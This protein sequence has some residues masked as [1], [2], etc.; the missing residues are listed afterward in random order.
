MKNHTFTHSLTQLI[1]CPGNRSFRCRKG[2]M[3][4]QRYY[5]GHSDLVSQWF[6]GNMLSCHKQLCAI[7]SAEHRLHC[8]LQCAGELSHQTV[9]WTYTFTLSN[10]K[11]WRLVR[12]QQPNSRFV[13]QKGWCGV[14]VG[15][16]L[17]LFFLQFIGLWQ[18]ITGWISTAQT[19]I[20][21]SIQVYVC[22]IYNR[23]HTTLITI[24]MT[25]SWRQHYR[26]FSRY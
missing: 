23:V 4:C 20:Q 21:Y 18:P 16:C 2:L 25:L 14:T 6:I 17:T 9:K 10:T 3:C 7:Y 15:S 26:H 19:H 1:W 5:T 11:W 24:T 22:S 8:L 13:A 12:M